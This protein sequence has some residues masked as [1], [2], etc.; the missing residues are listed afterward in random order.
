M[1]KSFYFI[2]SSKT[3]SSR[4]VTACLRGPEPPTASQGEQLGAMAG[5]ARGRGSKGRARVR[6]CP[7]IS[8]LGC[9][10]QLLGHGW[11]T[12]PEIP[13][14]AREDPCVQPQLGSGWALAAWQPSAP[15]WLYCRGQSRG[16]SSVTGDLSS[17]LRAAPGAVGTRGWEREQR[18]EDAWSDGA[19]PGTETL[20]RTGPA[21]PR[22]G[23]ASGGD[24]A[25]GR[26][27]GA[28]PRAC[29]CTRSAERGACSARC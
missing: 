10:Q 25:G 16:P 9:K 18:S 28:L 2:S 26:G 5:E 11:G 1:Y 14:H 3:S 19:H 8:L 7:C 20:T 24:G 6:A 13:S 15:C 22:H 21:G 23:R 17:A 4:M 12:C 27:R 29:L